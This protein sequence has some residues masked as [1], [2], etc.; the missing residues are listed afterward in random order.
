MAKHIFGPSLLKL[1]SGARDNEL[2]K[3]VSEWDRFAFNHLNDQRNV[4]L[5]NRLLELPN[6]LKPEYL[7]QGDYILVDFGNFHTF[8]SSFYLKHPG[9]RRFKSGVYSFNFD[10][11]DSN[12]MNLYIPNGPGWEMIKL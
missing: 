3:R 5:A 12:A 4:E 6:H 7:A 8:G 1:A 9:W 11:I 10:L 2:G